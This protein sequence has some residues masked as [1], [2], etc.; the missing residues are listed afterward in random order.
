[1]RRFSASPEPIKVFSCKEG[2]LAPRTESWVVG[3]R[4]LIDHSNHRC[5]TLNIRRACALAMMPT[6]NMGHLSYL[7]ASD[8]SVQICANCDAR[9]IVCATVTD[10]FAYLRCEACGDAWSIYER[11]QKQRAA[12][13]GQFVATRPPEPSD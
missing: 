9:R 4:I 11:R 8:V 2:V 6:Q 10:R 5:S 13:G 12:D 1:M 7:R 3:A